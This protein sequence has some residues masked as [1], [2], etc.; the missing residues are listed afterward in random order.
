LAACFPLTQLA[1]QDPAADLSPL[2]HVGVHL[3]ASCGRAMGPSHLPRSQACTV[4]R[5]TLGPPPRLTLSPPAAG[6]LEA[7]GGC[8]PEAQWQRRMVHF[9][10]NV[11]TAVPSGKVK[12]VAAMLKAIHAQ[13]DQEAARAQ[14]AHV[15]D[16][17]EG[18]RL[19]K[20][21]GLLREGVAET[22]T[23][24]AFPR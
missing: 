7:L 14:A 1:G 9:Y 12:E 11:F 20:A 24:L 8:F 19:S 13:E 2:L 23:S 5:R 10:R 15:A 3:S 6:L 16:K 17:L 4:V 22:L 18:M 21:A